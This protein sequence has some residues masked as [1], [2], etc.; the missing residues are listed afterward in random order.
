MSYYAVLEATSLL[1]TRHGWILRRCRRHQDDDLLRYVLIDNQGA[2]V[3]YAK[4]HL[5]RR[6]GLS[7]L[8]T[9]TI[10]T[11]HTDIEFAEAAAKLLNN[12]IE[13]KDV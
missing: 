3:T 10:L 5:R 8:E 13:T 2:A 1:I 7:L 11:H 4:L 9:L 12:L 6:Y